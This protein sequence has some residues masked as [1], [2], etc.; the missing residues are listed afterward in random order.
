L[1]F[2]EDYDEMQDRLHTVLRDLN[3]IVR[4]TWSHHSYIL[5]FTRRRVERSSMCSLS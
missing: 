5:M 1:K 3:W 2:Y 4:I